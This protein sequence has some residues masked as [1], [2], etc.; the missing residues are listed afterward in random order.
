[1]PESIIDQPT[2]PV[3]IPPTPYMTIPKF[4]PGTPWWVYLAALMLP[5]LFGGGL[6]VAGVS[7][8]T[9][10]EV[11]VKLEAHIDQF[12]DLQYNILLLCEAQGIRCKD[13]DAKPK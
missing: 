11:D 13:V 8:T 9:A 7:F 12:D 2:G 4:P 5:A 10:N 1:M 3:Q 6:S